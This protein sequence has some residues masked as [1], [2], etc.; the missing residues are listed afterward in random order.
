MELELE[1]DC[2]LDFDFSPTAN[3]FLRSNELERNQLPFYFMLL[4]FNQQLPSAVL[5][6]Y[7]RQNMSIIMKANEVEI[8]QLAQQ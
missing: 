3:I 5:W 6:R 1:A 4:L 8:T 7:G 2:D